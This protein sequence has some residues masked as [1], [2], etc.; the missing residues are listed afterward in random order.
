MTLTLRALAAVLLVAAASPSLALVAAVW[1]ACGAACYAVVRTAH[2]E[3][4]A[5]RFQP[6]TM[7]NLFAPAFDDVQRRARHFS[8]TF[9]VPH[10]DTLDGITPGD[11]VKVIHESE[12][13]WLAVQT[14]DGERG[15]GVVANDLVGE[16]GFG[17]GDGVRFERH[18]VCG[19]DCDPS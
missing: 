11:F 14:W 2:D 3:R 9:T 12:R 18:H 19:W 13:F 8:G 1:L 17:A 15:V 10:D 6:D 4:A 16:H 5:R 7:P